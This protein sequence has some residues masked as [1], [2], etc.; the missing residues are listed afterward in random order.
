MLLNFKIRTQLLIFLGGAIVVFGFALGLAIRGMNQAEERFSSFIDNDLA[1]QMAFSD[2][3]AQGL[4]M[5]QAIR[6]IQLDPT[7]KKAYENLNKAAVDFEAAHAAARGL[8]STNPAHLDILKRI[9]E[10]RGKQKAAQEAILAAVA[11]NDLP[12]AI[13]KTNKEETPVWREMKQLILDAQKGIS[14]GTR[15]AREGMLQSVKNDERMSSIVTILG[16]LGGIVISL[17]ITSNITRQFG[18]FT[19]HLRRLSGGDLT[20]RVEIH[21]KSELAEAA[22]AFNQFM[23]GLQNIV[24]TIKSD[25]ELVS[26]DVARLC[27]SAREVAVSARGQGQA[28]NDAAAAIDAMTRNIDQVSDNASSAKDI[29]DQATRLSAKGQNL[30]GD[31][32]AEMTLIAS[33]VQESSRNIQS[34]K[35]VSERISGIVN[36]IRDVADQT[37]LLALN[38]AIEAARAGEQGRGF[39]VVADEVRKLAERTGLATNEI[40]SMIETI[41]SETQS[42]VTSMEAGSRQVERGVNMVGQLVDPL[43]ELHSGATVTLDSLVELAAATRAQSAASSDISHNVERIAE[44]ATRNN[45]IME[46]TTQAARHLETL[47]ASL[48]GTVGR[49]RI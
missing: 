44:M 17:V 34:L 3:Y 45:A 4:Q 13:T 33:T 31:A 16:I 42:A 35:H 6:N 41:Q 14:E 22:G 20:Q 36:V 29:A 10:L 40:K 7:N 39:A 19:G 5:G 47:A 12:A 46:E 32:T 9:G 43:Q 21:D 37:N 2:M 26:A 25:A 18:L 28:V 11:G 38:A 27:D 1:Q 49:F 30:I 48:M 23:D 15:Q 8:S 24:R